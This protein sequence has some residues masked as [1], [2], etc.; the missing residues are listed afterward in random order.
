MS[1]LRV[2]NWVSAYSLYFDPSLFVEIG[3]IVYWESGKREH[4]RWYTGIGTALEWTELSTFSMPVILSFGPEWRF[5]RYFKA[6]MRLNI[7]HWDFSS[8]N[9]GTEIKAGL[10]YQYP[11]I[12]LYGSLTAGYLYYASL[13][14]GEDSLL[15]L[16]T[17]QF[18]LGMGYS[19]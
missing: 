14:T 18:T 11:G 5:G 17:P 12:P 6:D 3:S 7:L 9:L 10:T 8:L 4:Y 2:E 15:S 19:L 1:H 16:I 13:N